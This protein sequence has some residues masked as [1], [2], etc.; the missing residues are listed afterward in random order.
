M[1][2][3]AL[4][5]A[6]KGVQARVIYRNTHPVYVRVDYVT[7]SLVKDDSPHLQ[8]VCSQSSTWHLLSGS[9]LGQEPIDSWENL[10]VVHAADRIYEMCSFMALKLAKLT[11]P[12]LVHTADKAAPRKGL[13]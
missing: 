6:R 5:L 13:L 3:L 9:S 1:E 11:G 12:K 8:V 4:H 2:E 7:A 10:T